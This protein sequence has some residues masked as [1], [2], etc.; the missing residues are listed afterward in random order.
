MKSI[1]LVS[2]F[3]M[4]LMLLAACGG[5][6]DSSDNSDTT[7]GIIGYWQVYHTAIGGNEE[8][9]DYLQI[10]NDTSGIWYCDGK[11]V[12]VSLSGNSITLS[13]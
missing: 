12:S 10:E 13:S 6:S 3:C 8:G 4:V 11:N 7:T 9:G 1:Y 2:I 5:G